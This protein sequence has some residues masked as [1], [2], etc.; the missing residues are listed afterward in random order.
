MKQLISSRQKGRW[1]KVAS[2]K[3]LRGEM[4]CDAGFCIVRVKDCLNV[5]IESLLFICN[6]L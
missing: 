3:S 2:S 6:Y 1:L 5:L 4:T